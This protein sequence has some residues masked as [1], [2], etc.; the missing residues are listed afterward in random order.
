MQNLIKIMNSGKRNSMNSKQE[1]LSL[2]LD[3]RQKRKPESL[4]SQL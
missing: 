2:P 3:L 4:M 1:K